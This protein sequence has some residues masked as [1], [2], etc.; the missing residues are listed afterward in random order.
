MTEGP[1]GKRPQ[2]GR[3][4]ESFPFLI[5]AILVLGPLA[6]PLVWANRRFTTLVK[7]GLTLLVIALTFLL[8]RASNELIARFSVRMEELRRTLGP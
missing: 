1:S 6:L 7:I 3:W 8:L 4:H 5:G 2:D